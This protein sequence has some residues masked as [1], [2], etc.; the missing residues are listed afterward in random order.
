MIRKLTS[1]SRGQRAKPPRFSRVQL[2]ALVEEATIDCYND[3]EQA[4]GLFTMIEENLVVPFDSMILGVPVRVERIDIND[5][6]EMVA[7]CKRGGQRQAIPLVD[8]LLPSPPP[9]GFEWI[10]AYRHW[11]R[12]Q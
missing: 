10:A 9:A 2:D 3:E 5:A 6:G 4:M 7:I 12:G 1:R 11:A 8:L